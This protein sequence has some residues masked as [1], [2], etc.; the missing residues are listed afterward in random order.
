MHVPH[1]PK[2]YQDTPIYWFAVLDCA[3]DRGDL[4]TAARAQKELQRLGIAVTVRRQSARQKEARRV[5]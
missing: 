2:D 3:L 5:R 4:A 1:A